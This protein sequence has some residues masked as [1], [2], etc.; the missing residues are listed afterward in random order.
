[1]TMFMRANG[2]TLFVVKEVSDTEVFSL[3]TTLL[4]TFVSQLRKTKS[5]L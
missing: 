2:P 1:M 3:L 5:L 4:R